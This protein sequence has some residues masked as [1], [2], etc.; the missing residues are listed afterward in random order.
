MDDLKS[1][2]NTLFL[3]QKLTFNKKCFFFLKD[4]S[5]FVCVC[6]GGLNILIIAVKKLCFIV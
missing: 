5:S 1:N 3:S 2:Y 6:V 4:F